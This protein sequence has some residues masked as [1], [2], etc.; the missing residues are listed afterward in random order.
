M[1]LYCYIVFFGLYFNN[2]IICPGD[3]NMKT[4]EDM[5]VNAP[6]VQG[7]SKQNITFPTEIQQAVFKPLLEGKDVLAQSETGSGKT[8]AYI[9][10][11]FC[12]I[13]TN[14]RSAQAIILTPTHELAS[15]V[16][17]QAQLLSQNS[18][19]EVK[20][21]L[22]IGKASISRQIEKLKEKPHIIIGSAG[23]IL[24]LIQKRKIPAHT[25]KTIVIDE[26]DR[27]TDELNIETVKAV[28]KTTLKQRQIVMLSASI[29]DE[30]KKAAE[31]IMKE[32]NFV[33][34]E[35]KHDIPENITHCF[36]ECER[37]D[38]INLIR[39]IVHAFQD[40]KAI[41]FINNQENI[42]VTADKLAYHGVK[43]EAVYGGVY[44]TE[45]K[46]IIDDFR[47]GKINVLVASDIAARG[48]DIEDV[49]CVI[50]M[51]I[52]EEPIHYQH[53]CG[54]TGRMGKDGTVI[55]LVTPGEKKWLKKYEKAFSIKINEVKIF[56]GKICPLTDADR[57]KKEFI[58][59]KNKEK[60]GIKN[61]TRNKKYVKN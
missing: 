39:K 20:G 13:D 7:L 35:K 29:T 4:F 12:N 56:E 40:S 46:N 37:R 34:P 51:D 2:R 33:R 24:E 36:I 59:N 15:Q 60:L 47:N 55:S 58:K 9:V 30:T 31:E 11:L 45:R 41:V 28:I 27:M 52:P 54:R 16:Y 38:K 3:E 14:L 18:G 42:A 1:F 5:G 10:P 53:R 22:I 17:R 57:R 48:L 49:N 25:V 23:R 21:A 61:N 32:V 6:I 44:K 43:A 50:N 26:A 19:L 8:L